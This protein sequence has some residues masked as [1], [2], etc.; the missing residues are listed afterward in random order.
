MTTITHPE[1]LKAF[2]RVNMAAKL[3][4]LVA[5]F[6]KPTTKAVYPTKEF[7]NTTI[8]L[9]LVNAGKGKHGDVRYSRSHNKRGGKG[10]FVA[11]PHL[12]LIR[13]CADGGGMY[14]MPLSAALTYGLIR[15][16]EAREW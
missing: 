13:N 3:Q 4:Q 2:A 16:E 9:F 12:K 10:V 5:H 7:S 14:E 8:T 15:G 11:K 1:V 6:A